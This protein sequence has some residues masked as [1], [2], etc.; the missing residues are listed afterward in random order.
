MD[1][2]MPLGFSI[3]LIVL[4]FILG[5]VAT[6]HSGLILEPE[7]IHD[8]CYQLTGNSSVIG[9]VEEGKLICELPS[10]DSTQNIIVRDNSGENLNG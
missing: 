3:G 6:I 1:G 2:D 9:L 4:G 5:T 8:I 7:V 10:F